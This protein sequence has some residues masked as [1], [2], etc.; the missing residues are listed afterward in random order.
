MDPRHRLNRTIIGESMLVPRAAEKRLQRVEVVKPRKVKIREA[1]SLPEHKVRETRNVVEAGPNS[2]K[3]IR[4]V[5]HPYTQEVTR[6]QARK[7]GRQ[8]HR[9]DW[10]RTSYVTEFSA[11]M[12][13][14]RR[15]QWPKVTREG[16]LLQARQRL[17]AEEWL[18][19]GEE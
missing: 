3:L 13:E 7:S 2:P 14:S 5:R 18:R 8:S 16:K 4:L 17:S 10:E 19:E 12:A 9:M 6:P 1:K 11:A 15:V